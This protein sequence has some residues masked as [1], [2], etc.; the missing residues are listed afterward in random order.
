[1]ISVTAASGY[2]ANTGK[3]LTDEKELPST[4]TML[5]TTE[6]AKVLAELEQESE[7]HLALVF[8]GTAEKSAAFIE[9][10]DALIQELYA[11]PEDTPEDA[12]QTDESEGVEPGGESEA[13]DNEL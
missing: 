2:D 13:P 1:M 9:A 5:V 8:R 6:Q 4:V 7:L 3:P 11:E 12:A 10:Q